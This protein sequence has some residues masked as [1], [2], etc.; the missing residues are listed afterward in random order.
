MAAYE[1]TLLVYLDIMGFKDLI[2][3]SATDLEKIDL[4]ID[5][6]RQMKRQA[7]IQMPGILKT[8][9]KTQNFSDLI[10]R[11]TYPQS[12]PILSGP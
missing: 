3:D 6:L 7:G 4:I 10:V 9:T 5:T 2:N 1:K 12:E 8:R 11:A